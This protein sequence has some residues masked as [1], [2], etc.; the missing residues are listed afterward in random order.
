MT[1]QLQ[2]NV[3]LHSTGDTNKIND[4]SMKPVSCHIIKALEQ[5]YQNGEQKLIAPGSAFYIIIYILTWLLW[6]RH[7]VLILVLILFFAYATAP[8]LSVTPHAPTDCILTPHSTITNVFSLDWLDL[9]KRRDLLRAMLHT[10]LSFV[11]NV[12]VVSVNCILK[13][14]HFLHQLHTQLYCY[15]CQYYL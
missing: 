5:T 2:C 4:D 15:H 1:L 8:S 12:L 6:K 13:T 10:N 11:F 14:Q 3:Q 9:L 7:M